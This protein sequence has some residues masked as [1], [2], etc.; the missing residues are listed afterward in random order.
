M[1][2]KEILV[3]L[4]TD[5]TN[6]SSPVKKTNAA[7]IQYNYD[8]PRVFHVKKER[9]ILFVKISHKGGHLKYQE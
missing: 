3:N 6:N 9:G 8:I 1:E 4:T 5:F 2:T 7:F